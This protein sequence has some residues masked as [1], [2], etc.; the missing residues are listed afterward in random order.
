M[1]PQTQA[2]MKQFPNVKESVA[3]AIASLRARIESIELEESRAGVAADVFGA[4]RRGLGGGLD[5]TMGN[6]IR[7]QG[8]TWEKVGGTADSY[9][10]KA[11]KEVIPGHELNG[12]I[13]GTAPEIAPKSTAP[14]TP[15]APPK[16][17]K[18]LMQWMKDN[19]GKTTLGATAI[20]AGAGYLGSMV[21]DNGQDPHPAPTPGPTPSPTPGPTPAGGDEDLSGLIKQMKD[22][23]AGYE[24][25]DTPAW[26]QATS[27]AMDL[28]GR[29]EKANPAQVAQD[30]KAS[31]GYALNEDELDRWLRIARG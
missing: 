5:D 31:A 18:G 6:I 24:T 29:A 2:A 25:D 7:H 1:G 21:G 26:G 13:K 23:M 20:G 11:T 15:E 28:I 12:R 17:K 10:N 30:N 14:V 4:M 3:E 27:H 16:D 8:Q 9:I 22:L 19:P